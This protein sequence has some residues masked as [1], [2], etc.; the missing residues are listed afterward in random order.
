MDDSSWRTSLALTSGLAAVTGMLT[1]TD[2]PDPVFAA[3]AGTSVAAAAT[4]VA[5][6][7]Q[8]RVGAPGVHRGDA[9]VKALLEEARRLSVAQARLQSELS[10]VV[11]ELTARA[12]AGS[13]TGSSP[14]DPGRA[15]QAR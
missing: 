11:E 8:K 5:V 1:L 6:I 9:R 14:H 3:L 10:A 4:A 15:A 12:R 7:A 2:V 13:A